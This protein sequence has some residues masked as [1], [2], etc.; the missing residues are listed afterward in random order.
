MRPVRSSGSR[1]VYWSAWGMDWE[2][3]APDRIAELATRDA[4]PGAV[5]LFHD[6][7]RYAPRPGA[8]ATAEAL[9]AICAAALAAGLE[10]VPLGAVAGDA[11]EP[12]DR[13]APEG[14]AVRPAGPDDVVAIAKIH[15]EGFDDAFGGKVPREVLL[16]RGPEQRR[17]QWST[18]VSSP[19]ARSHLLVA[20]R[21]GAVTGFVSGGPS[22]DVDA[23]PSVEAQ[24]FTLFVDAE[25][26]GD[27]VGRAL[28]EASLERLAGEGF[29]DVTLWMV[30]DNEGGA[31]FY[32]RAGF[33]PDGA[34][35]AARLGIP[36]TERRV[37]RPLGA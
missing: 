23:R 10:L 11:E 1:P 26:R 8:S 31:R 18:V 15:A 5:L 36:V 17:E 4:A 2:S 19:A 29:R 25:A 20:E 34:E 9:P 37:R 30:P 35:R 16:Q 33:A 14:L 27:G 24:V 22:R 32:E 12:G 6:S 13:P 7:A 21:G 3:L 28:L